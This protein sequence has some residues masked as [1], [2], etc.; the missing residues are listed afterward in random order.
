MRAIASDQRGARRVAA[1]DCRPAFQG[2]YLG[3]ARKESAAASAAL[4]SR[5]P[6]VFAISS[7][8]LRRV[9][10]WV[11]GTGLERPAYPQMPLCGNENVQTSALV[12]AAKRRPAPLATIDDAPI[13]IGFESLTNL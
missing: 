11:A 3:D 12:A 13:L 2:R 9:A 10:E 6:L 7:V 4:E 1:L 8:A 5:T